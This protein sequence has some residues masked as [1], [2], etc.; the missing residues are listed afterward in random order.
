MMNNTIIRRKGEIK[1]ETELKT[2]LE[3]RGGKNFAERIFIESCVNQISNKSLQRLLLKGYWGTH[4][5]LK[6]ARDKQKFFLVSSHGSID[7]T[8]CLYDEIERNWPTDD[9]TLFNSCLDLIEDDRAR[10]KKCYAEDVLE[11]LISM[12]IWGY[13]GGVFI[14]VDYDDKDFNTIDDQL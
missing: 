6:Y 5:A 4:A 8:E 1:T 14:G 10:E 13:T 9:M 11:D 2:L 3:N 7:I 12:N